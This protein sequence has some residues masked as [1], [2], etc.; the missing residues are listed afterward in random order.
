MHKWHVFDNHLFFVAPPEDAPRERAAAQ[1]SAS[2][3][4]DATSPTVEGLPDVSQ[5]GKMPDIVLLYYEKK[6]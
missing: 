2:P 6:M 5:E 3:T 4:A 1:G